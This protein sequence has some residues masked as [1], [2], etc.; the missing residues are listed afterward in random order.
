MHLRCQPRSEAH[1]L[2]THPSPR[3]KMLESQCWGNATIFLLISSDRDRLTNRYSIRFPGRGSGHPSAPYRRTRVPT[4]YLP[5]ARC[6][7]TSLSDQE[8][9]VGAWRGGQ[10]GCER[11]SGRRDGG[12]QVRECSSGRPSLSLSVPLV[13]LSSSHLPT[14]PTA[15]R[16]GR[17]AP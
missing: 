13:V 1:L 15:R 2:H 3:S 14:A 7:W 5:S 8:D 4:T 10:R 6:S 17:K 11:R 12:V 16:N 9:C